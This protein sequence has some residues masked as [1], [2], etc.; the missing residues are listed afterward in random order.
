MVGFLMSPNHSQAE[1]RFRLLGFPVRVHPFFWIT[2]LILAGSNDL[3]VVLIWVAVCFASVL[4]HELGHAVAMRLCRED[5]EVVL[6]AFG[7]MTTSGGGYR[8]TWEQVLIS[9]AGPAAGFALAAL[10]AGFVIAT[11]GRITF[12]WNGIGLPMVSGFVRGRF[13]NVLINILLYVNILWGLLYLLPIYP[14]DGGHITRALWERYNPARGVRRS[15]FVSA[16]LAIAMFIAGIY[17]RS[18][19]MV[20]MF[21]LLA[22]GSIQMFEAERPLFR[23]HEPRR[24]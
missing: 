7:G 23:S 17:A 24:R 11:G 22:A 3:G 19:Y 15:L 21:G 13:W 14:L 8:Q 4:I 12:A 16:A 18:T 20:V 1:W 5:A 2:T 10:T 9:F 6:Y